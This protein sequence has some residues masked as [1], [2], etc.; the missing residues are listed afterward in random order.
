MN[1]GGPIRKFFVSLVGVAALATGLLLVKQREEDT[2][3]PKEIP[4]GE[5]VPATISLDKLRELGI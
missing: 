1:A 2:E 4:P 3:K 5:T